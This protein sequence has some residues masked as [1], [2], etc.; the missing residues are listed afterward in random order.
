MIELRWVATRI[1][2]N[3]LENDGVCMDGEA[4]VGRV[5]MTENR[6]KPPEW[7]W[8]MYAVAPGTVPQPFEFQGKVDTK[9]QAKAAVEEAYEH[10]VAATPDARPHW[11]KSCADLKARMERF[12]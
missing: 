10:F 2:G 7:R 6:S 3:V 11:Q 1:A 12:Q 5:R 8:S 9:E 4:N